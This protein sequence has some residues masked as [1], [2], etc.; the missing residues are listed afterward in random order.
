MA[1]VLVFVLAL[2]SAAPIGVARAESSADLSVAK[3]D[4]PD[5]VTEGN[6]LTY[7]IT[8]TN[9]GPATSTTGVTLTDTLPGGVSFVSAAPS[10]GSCSESGGIV[11]CNLGTMAATSTVAIIVTPTAGGTITNTVS[12]TS[13]A[14]DPNTANNTDTE[15]TT[16]NPLLADLSVTKSDSPDPVT[17]GSNLTYN[18]IVTNNG[19]ATSTPVTL[20]DT[21]PGGV[22]FVSAA[23]SQGSCSESGGT[24]TC[25]LG[26]MPVATQHSDHH[27]HP[28]G[29]RNHSQYSQREQ[30]HYRSQPRQ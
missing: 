23:P 2:V 26:T 15:T 20:T 6:N 14:T 21:L 25:S 1:G 19:P 29:D 17:V 28:Y 22:S 18:I 3:S 24:V 10:Q 27:R 12:V 16:V 7:N 13:A 5:P 30:R 8:V 4:S 9:N 11:T